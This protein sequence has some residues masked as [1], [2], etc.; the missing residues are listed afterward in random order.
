MNEQRFGRMVASARS[1]RGISRD[2]LAERVGV[3]GPTITRIELGQRSPSVEL[4]VFLVRELELDAREAIERMWV[5]AEA[6]RERLLQR[7]L[8][9]NLA[10]M[11]L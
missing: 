7:R 9:K 10:A 8:A 2:V 6:V 1:E 5:Q 4:F 11:A 3:A